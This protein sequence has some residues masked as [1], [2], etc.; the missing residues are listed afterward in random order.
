M[1]RL[2]L[3]MRQDLS[4][5]SVVVTDVG[6]GGEVYAGR[7]RLPCF[8]SARPH[9]DPRVPHLD[10]V[11]RCLVGWLQAMVGVDVFGEAV[12]RGTE[13]RVRWFLHA[14]LS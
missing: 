1:V 3:I 7:F 6:E 9:D 2:T 5:C 10:G 4:S 14:R 13:G 8:S 12:V 11:G